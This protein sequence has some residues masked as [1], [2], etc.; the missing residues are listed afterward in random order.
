M[1]ERGLIVCS[2]HAEQI[3]VVIEATGAETSV[4]SLLIHFVGTKGTVVQVGMGK[5]APQVPVSQVISKEL[6]YRGSFRYG[7]GDYA[8]AIS[9]V[10]TGRIKLAELVT[11][12]YAFEEAEKAF[13]A[14]RAGSGADGKPVIKVLM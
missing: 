13:A 5:D 11:H 9:L 2:L 1:Q 10:A 6:L 4:P 8:L 14:A 3:D 7:P 12:R